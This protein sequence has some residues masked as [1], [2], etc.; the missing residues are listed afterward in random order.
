MLPVCLG[1]KGVLWDA[2]PEGG[3]DRGRSDRGLGERGNIPTR[4]ASGT[5]VQYAEVFERLDIQLSS[6]Y[7]DYECPNGTFLLVILGHYT[8]PFRGLT[9]CI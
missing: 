2:R 3:E 6:L 4:E 1:L 8:Y 5:I 9:S 7:E